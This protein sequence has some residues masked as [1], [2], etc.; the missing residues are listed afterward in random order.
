MKNSQKPLLLKND[1]PLQYAPRNELGVVFLFAHVARRLQFRIEEIRAAFPDCIAYR[2]AG[3]SEKRVRIEFE[4]R[5]SSFRAHRHISKQCDCIVCWHHDWPDVPAR[6]EVISLK[7]F[8]GVQFKV[9]IQAAI[10]SQWHWLDER[11]RMDW[12]LSKRVTPGDLLLMYRASPECSII[13]I[14]RYA[15]DKLRRGKAGFRS[16]YA[17]FGDI[18]RICRLDSPIHLDDMRTHKVLR[19]ASFVRAN[20]QGTGLLVSEY[21]PYLHSMIWE[22]NPKVR[23]ALKSYAPDRL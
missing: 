7:T 6:I 8:F 22:R 19:N 10:A 23:K 21:W 1:A 17:Y 20:M 14:F 13:D 16:G 12:A 4:F 18:K 3:D 2:H 9:W 5:S 11:D 15:G